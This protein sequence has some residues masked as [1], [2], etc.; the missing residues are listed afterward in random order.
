MHIIENKHMPKFLNH[1]KV[2]SEY[3]IPGCEWSDWGSW[4]ECSETCKE[5]V[6]NKYR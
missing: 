3:Y 2:R 5:G 6:Q 1:F 4:G